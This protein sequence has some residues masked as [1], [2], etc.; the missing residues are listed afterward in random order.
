LK[1][2]RPTRNDRRRIWILLVKVLRNVVRVG[3]GGIAIGIMD[4]RKSVMRLVALDAGVLRTDFLAQSSWQAQ[5][6]NCISS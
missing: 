2:F 4:D 3:D 1:S 6:V 5:R